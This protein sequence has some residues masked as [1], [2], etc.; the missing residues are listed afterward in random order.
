MQIRSKAEAQHRVDQIQAFRAELDLV[1]QERILTLGA[2]QRAGLQDRKS[3][4]LNSS[5]T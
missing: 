1:E 2:E 4:R 3:T 5:H